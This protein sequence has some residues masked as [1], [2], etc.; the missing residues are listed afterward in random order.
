[1]VGGGG[2]VGGRRWWL[3][4]SWWG[5]VKESPFYGNLPDAARQAGFGAE[6]DMKTVVG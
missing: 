2:K 4:L 3:T 1:M 6:R 5:S